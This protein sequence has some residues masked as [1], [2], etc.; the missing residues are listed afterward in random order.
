MKSKKT[1]KQLTILLL[2]GILIFGCKK[3]TDQ[4]NVESDSELATTTKSLSL[5]DNAAP[6]LMNYFTTVYNTDYLSVGTGGLR[7]DGIGQIKVL[8]TFSLSSVTKAYLY[9]HG[10]SRIA[11]EVGKTIKLNT[12]SISGTNIG[13]TGTNNGPNG[14]PSNEVNTQAYRAEVTNLVKSSSSRIFTVS[15]FGQMIADGA[16][17]ILFYSDGDSNNN[18]DIVLF[19]GNDSNRRQLPGFPGL[20]N[21]PLDHTGWDVVLSGVKY[22]WGKINVTMHVADGQFLED[23]GMFLNNQK[24][25]YNVFD[26]ITVPGGTP[27]SGARWDIKPK[28]VSEYFIG[29]TDYLH[30]TMPDDVDD[31]LSLVVVVFN[32]PKGAAP[33][34]IIKV[35]FDYRPL[36]CPNLTEG[37]IAGFDETA[38]LGTSTFNVNEVDLTS[39]KLNGIPIEKSSIR[40][41]SAPYKGT[42]SGCGTCSNLPADGIKDLVMS[43]NRRQVLATFQAYNARCI[44]VTLTGKLLPQYGSTPIE[45]SDYISFEP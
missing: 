21:A 22:T 31:W 11:A 23:G 6:G 20:P 35:P 28:E 10:N 33:G 19:N 29:G 24:F 3:N 34:K 5:V 2:S 30:L 43:F 13:I 16:S 45:G 37:F 41:I 40:D 39:I 14:I 15:N 9:W 4:G 12:S 27:T 38:I 26:G 18:R 36:V 32:L 7:D 8:G 44:K 42:V 1:T 25:G 17:L